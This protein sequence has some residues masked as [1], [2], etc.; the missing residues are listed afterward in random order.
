M[1]KI[2]IAIISIVVV[3][4][5][6]YLFYK[7]AYQHAPITQ[8][9]VQQ[10]PSTSETTIEQ[11]SDK[12]VVT[13]EENVVIR[14]DAGFLPAT[15]RIK[16]GEMVIFKNEGTKSMWVASNP[17]PAHTDYPG[18]DAKRPYTKS[19]SYSFSFINFGNWKYH[20]HFSPAEGGTIIVE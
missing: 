7:S 4:L 14:T 13:A 17:H 6:G 1:K 20:N 3:V 10:T 18:F 5:G 11:P 2:I 12:Q 9:Q 15:L 16:K 8:I 19:E